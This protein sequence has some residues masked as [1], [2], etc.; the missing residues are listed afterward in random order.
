MFEGSG[1]RVIK[2][3]L[4]ASEFVE[5]DMIG[6]FYHPAFREICESMIYRRNIAGELS[7]AGISAGEVTIAVKSSCIS[8]ALGHRKS[9]FEY[10]K[11]RGIIIKAAG[12]DEVPIYKCE[13]R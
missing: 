11:E 9:N 7:A 6:G 12:D 10:F 8:K 2:C 13:L 1:V 3:G 4:H 5:K